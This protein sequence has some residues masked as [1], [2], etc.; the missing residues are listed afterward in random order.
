MMYHATRQTQIDAA[1]FDLCVTILH[2]PVCTMP[3]TLQELFNNWQPWS[4]TESTTL[5]FV[6]FSLQVVVTGI[7]NNSMGVRACFSLQ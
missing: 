5:P 2:F 1:D 4:M 7:G 3:P 6:A